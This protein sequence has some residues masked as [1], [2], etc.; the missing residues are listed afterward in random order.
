MA[1]DIYWLDRILG[2]TE[3]LVEYHI[4][5]HIHDENEDYL[6]HV[7][8]TYYNSEIA[9]EAFQKICDEAIKK[10]H[11]KMKS[12]TMTI[13]ENIEVGKI[14]EVLRRGDD[15]VKMYIVKDMD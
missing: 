10:K 1:R 3:P 14:Y 6:G 8:E 5:M 15:Y 11:D 12:W 13:P 2:A 9:I 7:P 4:I